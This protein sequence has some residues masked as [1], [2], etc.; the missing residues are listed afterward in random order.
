M[1]MLKHRKHLIAIYKSSRRERARSQRV[2]P[3]LNAL[4]SR[5]SAHTTSA[6]TLSS[7]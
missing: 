4:S 3:N 2:E 6:I 5:C 1:V 7:P